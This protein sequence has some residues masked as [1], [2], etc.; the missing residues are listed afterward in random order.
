M[1]ARV[2]DERDAR[3]AVQQIRAVDNLHVVAG[4]HVALA[5]SSRAQVTPPSVVASIDDRPPHIQPVPSA[6]RS[7][8]LGVPV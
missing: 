8:C 5:T 6:L 7:I 3:P 1:A 4:L 2:P